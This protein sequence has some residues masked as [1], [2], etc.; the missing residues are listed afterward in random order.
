[1]GQVACAKN[2]TPQVA[3]IIDSCPSCGPLTTTQTAFT[4]LFLA[5]LGRARA[6]LQQASDALQCYTCTRYMHPLLIE[7]AEE[8]A[9]SA[10]DQACMTKHKYILHP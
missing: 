7:M 3:T 1:M 6:Q 10:I 2:S 4:K 5:N 8:P 9:A